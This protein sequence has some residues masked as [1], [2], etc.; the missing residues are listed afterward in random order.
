M[1]ATWLSFRVRWCVFVVDS[2][3]HPV[4]RPVFRTRCYPLAHVV[5]HG[6]VRWTRAKAV[7]VEQ[8]S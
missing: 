5:A 4:W 8:I 7:C 1:I 3:D 2:L 6:A